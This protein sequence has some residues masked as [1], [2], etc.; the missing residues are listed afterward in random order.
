MLRWADPLLT[1]GRFGRVFTLDF[2]LDTTPKGIC[3]CRFVQSTNQS[4][5]LVDPLITS[6]TAAILSVFQTIC[7][8]TFIDGTGHHSGPLPTNACL[9]TFVKQSGPG[10]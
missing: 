4:C 8:R 3:V 5:L 7:S 9:R 10:G 1:V 6:R 2:L